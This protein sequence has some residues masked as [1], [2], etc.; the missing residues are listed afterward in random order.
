MK[1]KYPAYYTLTNK[2]Y[3]LL[4]GYVLN[5][6]WRG[7][8]H[9]RAVRRNANVG[10][11]RR[12]YRSF[13]S[14][15]DTVPEPK[16][17]NDD[18]NEKIFTIWQQGEEN[19][20]ELVKACFRSIRKNCKQELV[21]LDDENIFDYITLPDTIVQKY[22][23][24]KIG[25]AHFAD[26]CRVELLY[27]HGGIWMDATAFAT[28][29]IPDWIINQDFFMFLSG[30]SGY[31]C[32]QNCF[33]RARRGAYLLS[34]WRE[35]ILNHWENYSVLYGYFMH[36]IMFRVLV[37]NDARA[38]KYFEQMPHVAQDS[39]HIVWFNYANEPFNAAAFEKYTSG[40]FFQKTM[41]RSPFAK[42][43][44]PG[45]IA[46]VMINKMYKDK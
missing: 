38:Q 41:Y 29:P 4:Y 2:L 16:I 26:I 31:S 25:R 6:F 11:I 36:Q 20:P 33:I 1:V 34:A 5:P 22:R 3:F 14:V 32:V 43:P 30:R 9:F 23:A 45:S 35:L 12:I 46:D 39:T 44:I 10:R 18:T 8:R 17:V 37:E 13:A 19:A 15:L 42:N 27:E 24:G 21:V 40:A 7:R 28:A